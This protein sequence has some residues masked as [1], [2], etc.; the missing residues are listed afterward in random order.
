MSGTS[1]FVQ[2]SNNEF[3]KIGANLNFVLELL[4]MMCLDV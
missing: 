1:N 2:E 4:E 3:F